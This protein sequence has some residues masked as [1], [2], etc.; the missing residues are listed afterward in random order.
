MGNERAPQHDGSFIVRIWWEHQDASGQTAAHW[1]GW[2]QHVRDGSQIYFTSMS[3]LISF[4]ERETGIEQVGQGAAQ[5][6]G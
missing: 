5:G 1:R 4:V 6:L 3:D 2:V